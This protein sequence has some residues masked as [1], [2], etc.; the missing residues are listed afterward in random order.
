[1]TSY[2]Y[3]GITMLILLRNVHRMSV[4]D[5]LSHIHKLPNMLLHR[6]SPHHRHFQTLLS[7]SPDLVD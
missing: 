4:A 3:I 6:L 7:S 5:G 2:I 1:M